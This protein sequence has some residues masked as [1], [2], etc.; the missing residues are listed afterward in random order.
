MANLE[1]GYVKDAIEFKFDHLINFFLIFFA[2]VVARIQ[3]AA[4]ILVIKMAEFEF[5]HSSSAF[6]CFF[7]NFFSCVVVGI[8][9]VAWIL[10]T[11]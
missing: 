1:L 5:K 7:L 3:T 2:S 4:C 6:F 8:Q 10:A 9:A 11:M